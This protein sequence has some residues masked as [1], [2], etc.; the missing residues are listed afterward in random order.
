MSTLAATTTSAP[1]RPLLRGRLHQAGFVAALVA[2][3]ALVAT[4]DGKRLLGASVFAASAA[5][6]LGA[7]ALYHRVT[8]GARTRLWMRRLDHAGIYLLIAGTYTP[9]G[10]LSLHGALQ[11]SVL[12]VVWSAAGAAILMKLCWVH[13][14]KWLSAVLGIAIGWVGVAALPQLVASAGVAAVALLG[15]GGLA[16]TL[17]AVVYARRRPDPAPAVF[18][19][20][21]LF[22]AL[23][24]VALACHYVAIAF[25][26]VRVG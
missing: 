5:A 14:P 12:A 24:L 9:V 3:G 13:A 16:Y 15:A 19:Y 1:A 10:L 21:E 17:G 18:G 8:W 2:G 11:Q 6:M 23:T 4:L 7:S 25:F 22:H 20:H 26:V